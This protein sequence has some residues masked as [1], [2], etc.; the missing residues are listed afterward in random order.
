MKIAVVIPTVNR[1]EAL[2][3]ALEGLAGQT[4]KP[5]AVI[6]SPPSRE[7]LDHRVLENR[8]VTVV[9]GAR[10]AS[11][12]RNRAL[13]EVSEDTD[14]VAFF[15]DDA[16]ARA[17]YL[18]QMAAI[19]E[20]PTIIGATGQVVRDGAQEKRELSPEELAAA[21]SQSEGSSGGPLRDVS[22][23]YG[24]NMVVRA[25]EAKT[26]GFDERLPL[27][28]WLEDLDFSRQL[29]RYGRL[30]HVP[31]AV[32]VH[33]GSASGGRQQ[34]R[35]LGYSQISNVAH[36]WGKGSVGAA[37]VVR[38]VGRPVVASLVGAVHGQ[39]KPERRQRLVGMGLAFADL[40]RGRITPERIERL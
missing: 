23:L 14:L 2:A 24:A 40:V 12:Q 28:S 3:R 35:R 27:Y 29:L 7:M 38:L 10:G 26:V 22:G 34:H 9:D 36:L 37:D 33:Q 25:R 5:S 1:N 11:A 6:V 4:L 30:V 15:D 8:Q 39:E 13:L 16:V 17:D 31:A 18:E 19:F 32:C 20:D 21:L